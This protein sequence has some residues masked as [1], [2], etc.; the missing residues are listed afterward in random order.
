[1]TWV[2]PCFKLLCTQII[3]DMAQNMTVILKM[4]LSDD[5]KVIQGIKLFFICLIVYVDAF[6]TFLMRRILCQCSRI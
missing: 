3:N 6:Q 5:S 2:S 4:G 1:M